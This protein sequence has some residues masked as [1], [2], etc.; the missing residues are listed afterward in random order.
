MKQT[1]VAPFFV[2]N[3]INFGTGGYGS[4]EKRIQL[5]RNPGKESFWNDHLIGGG[6]LRLK[7]WEISN[8]FKCPVVGVCVTLAEQKHLLKKVGICSKGKSAHDLH[9][10]LVASCESENKLSRRFDNLLDRKF[11]KGSAGLF[12][13]DEE[14]FM[15]HWR[16]SFDAGEYGEVLW[17]AASRPNLKVNCRKEIFGMVHMAMHWNGEQR[18]A[19]MATLSRVEKREAENR[20][21]RKEAVGERR[22]LEKH[23]RQLQAENKA[24]E[25]RLSSTLEEKMGLAGRLAA[26]TN[27]SKV[28]ELEELVLQ[29]RKER[30]DLSD[31]IDKQK[32]QINEITVA[33]HRQSKS[34]E[35]LMEVHGQLQKSMGET[36]RGMYQTKTCDES[37][38]EF[39]LCKKR[40]LI[41][42]GIAR[43]ESLYRRIIEGSGGLL[44]YHDGNM[45]R[46]ARRLENRLRRSDIVLCPVNCNSHAACLL[47]KNLGKKHSKPV[48]MM[49]NF[50]LNAIS[51]VIGGNG[52]EMPRS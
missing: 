28:P 44:E 7:I 20:R 19:S 46:G 21:R 11:G 36:V 38:P 40:V 5:I 41:V 42:G 50:S 10:I 49:P 1:S 45:N 2:W 6:P 35:Q 23:I 4:M 24:L 39:D 15:D 18:A 12:E 43:M 9:E 22:S 51:K 47:V 48:H 25:K 29:L 8:F 37:C 52:D 13:M 16:N 32:R 3:S 17:A 34:Y 33:L 30:M 26:L 31:N 27:E 14:E